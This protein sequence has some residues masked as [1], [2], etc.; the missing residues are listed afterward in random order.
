MTGLRSCLARVFEDPEAFLHFIR[1]HRGVAWQEHDEPAEDCGERCVDGIGGQPLG[2][3][4]REQGRM[5]NWLVIG[6]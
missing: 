4:G 3:G 5:R 2:F 1:A 6:S